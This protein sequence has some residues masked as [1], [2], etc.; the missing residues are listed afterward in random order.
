M[1]GRNPF[2]GYVPSVPHGEKLDFGSDRCNELEEKGAHAN[3]F[4]DCMSVW[5]EARMDE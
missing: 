1:P 5:D 4:I 3:I 2:E